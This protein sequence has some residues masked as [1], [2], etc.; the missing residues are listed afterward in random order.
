MYSQTFTTLKYIPKSTVR[1]K[2]YNFRFKTLSIIMQC[3]ICIIHLHI[4][5]TILDPKFY[6]LS[7]PHEKS[8]ICVPG[9]NGNCLLQ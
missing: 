3:E 2:H 1:N 7:S 6:Y 4:Y 5:F 9:D 8:S